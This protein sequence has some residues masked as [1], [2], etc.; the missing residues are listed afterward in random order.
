[1]FINGNFFSLETQGGDVEE[2]R[3]SMSTGVGGIFVDRNATIEIA[4]FLRANVGTVVTKS[5]NGIITLPRRQVFFD[6]GIGIAQWQLN[7]TDAS[8]LVIVPSDQQLSDYTLDWRNVTKN[9]NGGFTPFEVPSTPFPCNGP[10]V[11]GSNLTSLPTI[12]G[13]VQQMQIKNSRLGD[14]AHLLIDGGIVEELVM[15]DNPEDSGDAPVGFIVLQNDAELGLGTAHRNLDSDNA[16]VVLGINGIELIANGNAEV[17]LNEDT[18]INNVCHIMTGTGFGLTTPQT[19]RISSEVPRELRIA[20]GGVLDLSSFTTSNQNLVIAGEVNLVLEPGATL[21]MGGGNLNFAEGAQVA[22]QPFV[23]AT[24]AG[25]SLTSADFFRVKFIGNGNVIFTENSFIDVLR[26]AA[27]GIETG[28]I[29]TFVSPNVTGTSCSTI[30]SQ[31]WT[32]LDETR[33]ILGSRGDFGGVFQIGNTSDK[34]GAINFNLT[35]NG[36]GAFVDLN[37]QGFLGLGAGVVDKPEMAPNNWTVASLFNVNSITLNFTQGI[38]Q[39]SQIYSGSDPL[40]GLLAIGNVGAF[41]NTVINPINSQIRGGGNIVLLT[42]SAIITPTVLITDGVINSSLSVGILGSKGVMLDGSKT[43]IP[44]SATP[45]QMYTFLKANPYAEQ[46]GKRAEIFQ[47]ALG[48][49]TIGLVNDST[50]IRELSGQIIGDGGS[51]VG[52]ERSVNIG[53]VGI[54]I[55]KGG[56]ITEY[57]IATS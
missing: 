42:S 39:H 54:K 22:V 55:D 4:Q 35:L 56:A 24:F 2:P 1:L 16:Q 20:T 9:F 48:Q 12:H 10:L 34:G 47:S 30:T 25:T 7:L 43:P 51:S 45:T 6:R 28:P 19:L 8:Q 11:M 32:F 38:F 26:G 40:A 49:A 31:T 27:V 52:F 14:Q 29:T 13:L 37:S 15:L 33:L 36:I 46:H 53:A 17:F 44:A 50:I 18:L 3:C 23:S 5:L 41:T 57:E 21:I